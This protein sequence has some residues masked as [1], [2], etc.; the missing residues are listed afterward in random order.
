M[1]EFTLA[2]EFTFSSQHLFILINTPD[3]EHGI[4]CCECA[5]LWNVEVSW[6]FFIAILEHVSKMLSSM[7]VSYPACPSSET[8]QAHSDTGKC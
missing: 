1:L 6:D 7:I 5:I 8:L 4:K 2:L 3:N